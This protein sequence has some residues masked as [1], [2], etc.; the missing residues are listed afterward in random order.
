M[1]NLGLDSLPANVEDVRKVNS[2]DTPANRFVK[3]VLQSVIRFCQD[4]IRSDKNGLIQAE[5][6]GIVKK[7]ESTLQ[8]HLFK[9]VSRVSTII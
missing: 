2:Y 1:S 5:A 8:N 9:E 3:F 7:C 6:M 4:I